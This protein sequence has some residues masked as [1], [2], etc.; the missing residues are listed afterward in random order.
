[1]LRLEFIDDIDSSFTTNDFIIGAYFLN[2]CTHFHA[3]H[4]PSL[5]Y[6]NDTLPLID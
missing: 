4:A 6:S 3:D 1:M 2:A 5:F